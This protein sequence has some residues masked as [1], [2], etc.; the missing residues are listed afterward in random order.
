MEQKMT[1]TL[2]QSANELE[3]ALN[4]LHKAKRDL[5][6]AYFDA[7]FCLRKVTGNRENFEKYSVTHNTAEDG[8]PK[9]MIEDEDWN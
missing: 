9:Q 2:E 3:G 4:R 8:L 6:G 5:L 1:K 7:F